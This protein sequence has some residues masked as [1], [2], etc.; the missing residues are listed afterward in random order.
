MKTE[1]MFPITSVCIQDIIQGIEDNSRLDDLQRVFL[2][3]K[4]KGLNKF[5]MKWIAKKM[6][7]DYCNN[8]FWDSLDERF[9]Q[10]VEEE[11]A[12]NKQI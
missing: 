12:K 10:I 5:Q 9:N 4:A 11:N 8:L 1:K 3:R 2:I 7:D 6:A